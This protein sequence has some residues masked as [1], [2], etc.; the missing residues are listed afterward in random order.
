MWL[1]GKHA[2]RHEGACK[3]C[4]AYA[5]VWRK[6]CGGCGS[7]HG[8]PYGH[9]P[10]F[11]KVHFHCARTLS[12]DKSTGRHQTSHWT[13]SSFP[14][15][16]HVRGLSSVSSIGMVGLWNTVRDL[17]NC[18]C[19]SFICQTLLLTS[20]FSLAS[21]TAFLEVSTIFLLWSGQRM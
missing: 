12:T 13:C 18:A 10:H 7:D 4:F 6:W 21:A 1:A 3:V 16:K 20:K 19:T 8:V 17:I 11:L 2:N 15:Q 14:V 5:R 9:I